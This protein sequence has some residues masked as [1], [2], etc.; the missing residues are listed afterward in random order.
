M[1]SCDDCL[2]VDNSAA[3]SS[4]IRSESGELALIWDSDS[5][6]NYPLLDFSLH[7]VRKAG[8]ALKRD[9]PMNSEAERLEAL[10]IF[11]IANSWRDSHLYP[12][13]KLRFELRGHLQKVRLVKSHW[14]RLLAQDRL[15][16]TPSLC[17]SNNKES[18]TR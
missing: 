6:A 10:R 12:M 18:L 17:R 5:V 15:R 2:S 13:R 4:A 3:R 9:I 11:A 1:L 14:H 16:W 7:D 8:E